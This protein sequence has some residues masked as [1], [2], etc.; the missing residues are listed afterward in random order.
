[1]K[2]IIVAITMLLIFAFS[3]CGTDSVEPTS[4]PTPSESTVPSASPLAEGKEPVTVLARLENQLIMDESIA[5]EMVGGYTPEEPLVLLDPYGVAPL[6][7]LIIFDTDEA[8]SVTVSV[9]GKTAET[10][11]THSFTEF[12]THHEIPVYGL[13][14]DKVNSVYLSLK[15]EEGEAVEHHTVDIETESLP[16]YLP[17]YELLVSDP[18]TAGGAEGDLL[19]FAA[20]TDILYP[21]AIDK[22]GDVRW[23]SSTNTFAGGLLRRT[24]DGKLL[25]LS[26]PMYAPAFIRPGFT[27]T[28]WMGRVYDEYLV[29][30][31]HHDV[32]EL[33]NG[34]YLVSAVKP[35]S[36]VNLGAIVAGADA[37]LEIDSESGETLRSWDLNAI[38]GYTA[39]DV[40]E[41]RYLHTNAIHYNEADNSI[42]FSAPNPMIVVN[43]DADSGEV[44][45]AIGNPLNNYP[46]PIQSKILTPTEPDFLW[47]GAIHAPTVLPDGNIML[48]DNGSGRLDTSGEPIEDENNFS[49]LVIFSVDSENMTISTVYE[50]G[51]E[52]GN[53]MY[54]TYLGDVDYLGENHY[55]LNA[56]GRIIDPV[57]GLAKGS[58]FDIFMGISRGEGVIVEILNGEV[59]FE[60]FTGEPVDK[61]YNNVYRVEWLSVYDENEPEY[62]VSADATERMGEL[63]ATSSADFTLPADAMPLEQGVYL[64]PADYSY[65]LNVP[66]FVEG[67]EQGD[68][69][70]LEL[71]SEENSYYY[72]TAGLD[73]AEG[74]V[75]KSGL[76]E[77]DYVLGVVLVKADG[78][79]YHYESEYVWSV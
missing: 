1:M 74:V 15:Y 43:F 29:D 13:Y 44:N 39:E 7:A 20:A 76:P 70:Y 6:T 33:P 23:Y 10:T 31:T 3:A 62:N 72:L 59:V 48:F 71:K 36:V 50:Y 77:G 22:E 4:T 56:G 75:Q 68:M 51:E 12:S 78:S 57:S 61:S 73:G 69:V 19:F 16:D 53:D 38:C 55:I 35:D 21:F 65:Q 14:A 41:G 18:Q 79:T 46:E 45:W 49:R 60:V 26:D 32:I 42:M 5:T 9:T 63:L 8:C 58:G 24:A 66:L 17:S 34:N 28:D 54:A 37:I 47:N 27:I 2:K 67:T 52:R 25:S 11:F 64:Y 30:Y 40:L